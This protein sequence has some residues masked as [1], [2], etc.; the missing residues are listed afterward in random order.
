MSAASG[1]F[2]SGCALPQHDK[3]L[4]STIEG[5]AMCKD[6]KDRVK[7]SDIHRYL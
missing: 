5:I 4:P 6:F 1:Y 7:N 3:A 2:D